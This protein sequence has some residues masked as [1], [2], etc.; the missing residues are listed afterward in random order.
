MEKELKATCPCCD[1]ILILD[2]FSGKILETR[3]PLVKKSTG[4]RLEDA[5]LKLDEDKKKHAEAF[6][7]LH[8]KHEEQK[9]R[10]NEFFNASLDSAKKNIDEKPRS[11]FDSD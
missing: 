6:D 3:K 8:G 5:F 9:K 11:I 10:A 2:R 7:N 4:D 1:T